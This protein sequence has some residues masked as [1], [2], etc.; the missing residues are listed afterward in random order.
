MKVLLIDD[1]RF[2]RMILRS[3]LKQLG[4]EIIS[5][6]NGEQAL[7]LYLTHHPD[8]IL[9]DV[10]MPIM[11]GHEAA[12]KIREL[13]DE[14]VPIIFLSA[15]ENA[16]DIAAGI[17]AGGD[18]YLVKPIDQI[19]LTAKMQAMQRIANMRRRLLKVS[20]AL[21]QANA[22]L[23]RLA[24]ADGLTGLA[25]RRYLDDCLSREAVRC[26]RY[27]LPM[28]V[29]MADIDHFKAYNDHYGHLAGDDCLRAV[30]CALQSIIKRQTDL[31]A[32]YG[33]EEFCVLLPDTPDSIALQQAEELRTAVQ[34]LEIPHAAIA[35]NSRLT[36]TLGVAT[37]VPNSDFEVERLLR[38]ADEALYYAKQNGRNRVQLFALPEKNASPPA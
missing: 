14:W 23:Q 17:E 21:E 38:K 7:E 25:N 18:D 15:K 27:Q 16:K 5:G 30:A 19:V 28:S 32:R 13:R 22:E 20:Q 36:L 34:T 6:E 29:I 10:L 33:G 4:H 24:H 8:L 11:N 26:A 12:R 1:T 2:D 37:C 35:E 9:L 3:Y 31:V